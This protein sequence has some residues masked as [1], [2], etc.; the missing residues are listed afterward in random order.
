[1]TPIVLDSTRDHCLIARVVSKRC[2]TADSEESKN[3]F[4]ATPNVG[5]LVLAWTCARPPENAIVNDPT[6]K[7]LICLS[8]P[9]GKNILIFRRP[10]SVYIRSRP[11]PI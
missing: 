6:G 4:V 3:L 2:N 9:L 7:S 5:S 8:S 1:V 11:V 10:K